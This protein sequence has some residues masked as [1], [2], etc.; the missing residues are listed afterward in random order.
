[1]FDEK[2][3]FTDA[4][5][6]NVVF[7]Y[8]EKESMSRCFFANSFLENAEFYNCDFPYQIDRFG[9]LSKD[10]YGKSY[11]GSLLFS[12]IMS[13]FYCW[14]IMYKQWGFLPILLLTLPMLY[15]FIMYSLWYLPNKLF[16]TNT[17]THKA[18]GDDIAMIKIQKQEHQEDN[19]RT[20]R[21][22]Y[23][24]LK[25]NFEKH[26]DYQSAGDF[27]YSQRY[28]EM[29][30]FGGIFNKQFL[31]T[32]IL[33][34][35]YFINGFGERWLRAFVWFL[36][37]IFGFAFLYTPNEDFIST[38]STPEH[39]FYAYKDDDGTCRIDFNESN[40]TNDIKQK[41]H[42][43]IIAKSNFEDKNTTYKIYN[44]EISTAADKNKT[45]FAFDNRFD[46]HS[47]E[48]Y[49][50]MLK[51]EFVTKLIYSFSKT[52]APFVSDERKW[53]QDRSGNAHILAFTESILLW[54]FFA[55]FA[56]AVNNRIRR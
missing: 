19:Y 20:I 47:N 35:H 38:K 13:V 36:L 42:F 29:I 39:F 51:D 7:S 1:M 16:K 28:C 32:L 55:A 27:Y 26:G 43:I 50:P 25:I 9:Y 15:L 5:L 44:K 14:I 12:I 30:N 2:A 11:I 33:G 56:V 22:V 24:Q 45:V 52:I 54:I 37:T 4:I 10:R 53:F 8:I 17:S 34:V 23:R 46:Y 6:D 40:A 41:A 48:Q 31:Q 18:I 3:E 49:I 21:E